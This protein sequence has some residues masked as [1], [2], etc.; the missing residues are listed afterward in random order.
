MNNRSLFGPR[1]SRSICTASAATLLAALLTA[2]PPAGAAV[3]ILGGG[4]LVTFDTLPAAADWSTGSV[5]GASADITTAA[6]LDAAV[7]A[8][9]SSGITAPLG[10][11]A[12]AQDPLAQF[13]PVAF[14]IHTRPTSVR[15]NEVMATLQNGTGSAVSSLT[16]S[17]NFGMSGTLAESPGLWGHRV[18]FSLTGA[19][20]SWTNATPFNLADNAPAQV[21]SGTLSLGNWASGATMFV[22]WADDNGP[23]GPDSGF[24]LDNV[25]F[26]PTLLGRNLVYNLGHGVGGAPHGSLTTGGGNYWLDSVTPAAFAAN[27]SITFSQDGTATIDVPAPGVTAASMTVSHAS[28]T[29]TIGGAGAITSTFTK[30]NAGSLVLTSA[31]AFATRAISG[32]N[33][34]TRAN[35]ALGPLSSTHKRKSVAPVAQLPRLSVPLRTCAGA[36]SA[37]LN[38]VA[39]V[40]EFA[41]PVRLK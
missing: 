33:V 11:L 9:L 30:S 25:S 5:A 10:N 35:G 7:A 2:A 18:Y 29:Y 14:N 20:G 27:D 40:H 37:R 34:E 8:L 36:L 26:T 39:F 13:D 12:P 32:G 6:G 15:F 16:L 24:T 21:L 38:G 1:V 23:A 19:A 41:A 4:T 17:Y 31:N 3:S 22:L 28:G